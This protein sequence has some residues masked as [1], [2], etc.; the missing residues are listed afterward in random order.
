M[1]YFSPI[2]HSRLHSP[3]ITDFSA[4]YIKQQNFYFAN[5]A[6]EREEIEREVHCK[7][8]RRTAEKIH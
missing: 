1:K 7:I 8:F 5:T 6:R 4:T 3:L 2:K